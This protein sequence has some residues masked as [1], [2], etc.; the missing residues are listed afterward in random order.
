MLMT[1]DAVGAIWRY[2]LDLARAMQTYGVSYHLLGIGPGPDAAMIRECMEIPN[3]ELSWTKLPLDW[4]VEDERALDEVAI[5][6]SER[7]QGWRADLLHLNV[8]SQAA[9]MAEGLPVVVASHS[10]VATRWQAMHS[11]PPPPIWRWQQDYHRA[12]LARADG[13]MVPSQSHGLA[14]QTIYGTLPRLFVVANI[15]VSISSPV[16]KQPFVLSAGRWWD[17]GKNGAVLDEAAAHTVWSVVMAGSFDGPNGQHFVGRHAVMRGAL[18]AAAMLDLMR[19]AA[20]FAAPSLHEPFD[21][22]VLQA[23]SHGAALILADIPTFRELWDGAAVFVPA[24]DPLAWAGT[25]EKLS[26]DAASTARFASLARQR[27]ARFTPTI[28]ADAVLQAYAAAM[29]AHSGHTLSAI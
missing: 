8:P 23:A 17:E 20:L 22:A 6:I 18:T 25:I 27:A 28:Q 29:A 21:Q 26:A 9:G 5:V 11:D 24:Q 14:I 2:A 3:V 4:M 15:T 1:V 10:C 7:A 12:G 19:D 16:R 13:V